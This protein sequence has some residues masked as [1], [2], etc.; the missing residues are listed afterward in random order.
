MTVENGRK[1]ESGT[2][3]SKKPDPLKQVGITS[4]KWARYECFFSQNAS[5]FNCGFIMGTFKA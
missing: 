2:T 4:S 1:E 5:A 3:V